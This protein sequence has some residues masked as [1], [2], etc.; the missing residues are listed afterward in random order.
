MAQLILLMVTCLFTG[1]AVY[2]LVVH[3]YPVACEIFAKTVNLYDRVLRQRL[4]IQVNPTVTVWAT[5]GLSLGVGLIAGLLV[6]SLLIGILVA[7]LAL[8]S[9]W[10]IFNYLEVKRLNKLE[11]QLVDG[12]TTIASGTRAGLNL[13]QSMDLLV[14]NSVGPI[15]QEFAQLLSEY[16]MG[17]D[18]NRAMRNASDR[19]GSKL[20]RLTFTAMEMHRV[21][22]GDTA[23]SM[24]RIAESVREITKLEGKLDALTAQGRTQAWM[25]ALAAPGLIGMFYMIEPDAVSRLFTEPSG[26]VILLIVIALI[27][28]GFLWMRR[29]L[30]IDI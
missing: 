4:L 22:G 24:D 7:A 14:K 29:I 11:D 25:M 27:V 3:G 23:E 12:L 9:P 18:L 19:I 6:S 28:T 2:M 8:G 30:A 5:L 26:R 15:Q 17:I 16:G 1:V 13:V 20:Y 21:R 10:L